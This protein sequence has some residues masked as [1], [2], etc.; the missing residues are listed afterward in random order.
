MRAA[1]NLC[2]VRGGRGL[3][4]PKGIRESMITDIIVIRI[5]ILLSVKLR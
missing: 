2:G 3:G 1:K 4:V 5:R